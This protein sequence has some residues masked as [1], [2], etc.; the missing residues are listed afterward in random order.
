MTRYERIE[1]HTETAP[2]IN[3]ELAALCLP[4]GTFVQRHQQPTPHRRHGVSAGCPHSFLP[5]TRCS[6]DEKGARLI[7]FRRHRP[8]SR[9]PERRGTAKKKLFDVLRA[10]SAPIFHHV[11][12]PFQ[13]QP[14]KGDL[15]NLLVVAVQPFVKRV[16][17]RVQH[18]R[19]SQRRLL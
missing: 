3:D 14:L 15:E 1:R 17:R 10:F 9:R 5:R 16:S 13:C 11:P 4:L 7:S 6:D 2:S 12:A 19:G 18:L 8:Y